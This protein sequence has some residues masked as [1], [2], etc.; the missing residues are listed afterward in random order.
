MALTDAS[1][2]ASNYF[3]VTMQ[4]GDNFRVV[5]SCDPN[6]GSQYQADINST[7]GGIVDTNGN[8]IASGY[9]TEML[10]VWRRLHVEVDSMGTVTN[11][12]VSANVV[13]ISGS[14]SV[15]TGLALD[16]NLRT[17]LNPQDNSQNLS[18]S[19]PGNGRF[20]NGWVKIGVDQV[21]TTVIDGNGD[22]FVQ[23][24]AGFNLPSQIVMNG[25]TLDSGQVVALA[26]SLF[27][28]TGNLGTNLYIGGSFRVAGTSFTISANT[29]NTVTVTGVSPTIPIILHDDDRPDGTVLGLPDLGKLQET[30]TPA[31]VLPVADA[32]VSQTNLQFIA[33]IASDNSADVRAGWQFD[34]VAY[35]ADSTYWTVYVRGAFEHTTDSDFDPNSEGATLGIVDNINGE[36]ANIYLEVLQSGEFTADPAL[37]KSEAY[38]VAHEIGHLFG[39]LHTDGCPSGPCSGAGL[40][41]QTALRVSPSFNNVTLVKI[42]SINHP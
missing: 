40:M 33:N 17:G 24:T 4:P 37:G 11:N 3:R 26:G 7:T 8:P 23:R 10:T 15:A 31:Y 34:A 18:D 22:T 35:E 14:S 38:T 28:V 30:Y 25:G 5:A 13:S 32:G 29:A 27:T 36:G 20:E 6:F 9:V 1:G 39:G 16:V 12:I 42:R 19:P 21:Q 2:V 41:A